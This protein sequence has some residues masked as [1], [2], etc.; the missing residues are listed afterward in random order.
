MY[1][2]KY[3]CTYVCMS[4]CLYVCMSVC[5]YVCMYVRIYVCAKIH[6][7]VRMYARAYVCRGT[8]FVVLGRRMWRYHLLQKGDFGGHL[9]LRQLLGWS[10]SGTI[11][12]RIFKALPG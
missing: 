1:L 8:V 4:V 3:V 2:C 7:F 9:Y 11:A 6:M 10:Y 5:M 12:P